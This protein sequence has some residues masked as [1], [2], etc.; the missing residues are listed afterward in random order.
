L[1]IRLDVL[2]A[3]MVEVA[4]K[5]VEESVLGNAEILKRGRELLARR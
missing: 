5:G 4:V 3:V 1:A 2:A